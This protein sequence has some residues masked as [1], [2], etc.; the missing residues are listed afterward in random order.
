MMSNYCI[1]CNQPAETKVEAVNWGFASVSVSTYSYY[2][3]PNCGSLFRADNDIDYDLIYNDEYGNYEETLK[4]TVYGNKFSK[5]IRNLRNA[6]AYM[7][8]HRVVGGV[9]NRLKPAFIPLPARFMKKISEGAKLLDV[10]CR[11]GI[12]DYMLKD[13]GANVSGIEPYL[14]KDI[15]Y[16]N[17]LVIKKL[18]IDEV[19]DKYDIILYDNVFEHLETPVNDLR[20][21][22]ERL[23]HDGSIVLVFPG[24]GTMTKLY[25]E[26]SYI[27]Q[28][29]Q[30]VCLYTEKG[31]NE[32]AKASGLKVVDISRTSILQWYLKSYWIQHRLGLTTG[33]YTIRELEKRIP[34]DELSI[35]KERIKSSTEGD[36]F[37]VELKV[38]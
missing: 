8:K 30:H 26:Y 5:K 21:A 35:I 29:P 17:G 31:V 34:H 24:Y 27:I 38:I 37:T 32:V 3:C 19:D 10:G 23:R 25:G 1:A 33:H 7:N 18:F 14:D 22:A 16:D 36:L 9:I 12:V 28:P 20:A 2:R 13:V 4:K 11:Y 15:E 6:Y